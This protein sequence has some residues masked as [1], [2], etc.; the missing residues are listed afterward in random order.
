MVVV[1]GAG[2]D[3]KAT[4]EC[5]L[6]LLSTCSANR[7]VGRVSKSQCSAPTSIL[8]IDCNPTLGFD[9]TVTRQFVIPPNGERSVGGVTKPLQR[10]R[11]LKWRHCRHTERSVGGVIRHC[12][13]RRTNH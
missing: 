9:L 11:G 6:I 7:E 4:R 1:G 12:D 10:H 8:T 3:G 5:I 2:R 13:N